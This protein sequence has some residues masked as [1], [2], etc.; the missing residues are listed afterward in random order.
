MADLVVRDVHKAFGPVRALAGVSLTVPAGALAAVLGPSGCGKTTLLRC[1]AGFER[2]DSGEILVGGRVV[3]SVAPHR[4]RVAV[5]PQEAALFPHLSVFDNVAYG[6]SRAERRSGR[7][8]TVL[9]L[10]GL[11]GYEGR[12]PHQLSGGQQHRVAVAR[13]L[14]PRPPLVLLD[15]PFGSLDAALRADIRRDVREALRADS[16][17]AVLVTHDQGEALSMADEVAVMRSGR[18]IQCGP[19][20][21]VYSAPA[22]SWVA[23][24]IGEAVLLPAVVT[25]GLAHTVLGDL[26]LASAPAR[27]AD[28]AQT[29]ASGMVLLRPEQ[30]EILPAAATDRIRAT[31]SRVDFHG[32]DALLSLRLPDGTMVAARVLGPAGAVVGGEVAVRVRG[33]AR[34]L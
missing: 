6:L 30:L 29:D 7:V 32:H 19:P 17:T 8:E 34:P 11:A 18:I 24:F 12:M 15:E 10:V 21:A 3:T 22:D 27:K 1:I 13:A 33:A 25:D 31:V 5:V 14:A 26:P 28:G 16:A 9:G 23:S 4:R 20:E 2:V